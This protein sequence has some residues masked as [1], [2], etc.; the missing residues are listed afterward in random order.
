MNIFILD[1]QL[2]HSSNHQI[3]KIINVQ[4]LLSGYKVMYTL[5]GDDFNQWIWLNN[6]K[7]T[8]SN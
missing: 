7:Q 2:G 1:S 8:L 3:I 4:K 6:I 5:N